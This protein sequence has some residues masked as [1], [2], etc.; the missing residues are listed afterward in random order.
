MEFSPFHGEKKSRYLTRHRKYTQPLLKGSYNTSL[1]RVED[2]RKGETFAE[3]YVGLCGTSSV[4]RDSQSADI[5]VTITFKQGQ[6]HLTANFV[7]KIIV[8]FHA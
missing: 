4:S 6:K 7:T 5:H 3:I 8:V 1:L 2:W